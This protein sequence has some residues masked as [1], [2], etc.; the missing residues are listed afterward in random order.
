[1]SPSVRYIT[2]VPGY[3][4]SA[5]PRSARHLER[6]PVSFVVA[7]V[8]LLLLSLVAS[9]SGG[10][11][12]A[13]P[14]A[15]LVPASNPTAGSTSSGA[16]ESSSSVPGASAAPAAT[17]V[18]GTDGAS[19]AVRGLNWTEPGG[20]D[21][22]QYAV[23]ESTNGSLGPWTTVGVITTDTTVEDAVSS[24][25]PGATYW[26]EVVETYGLFGADTRTSNV[27]NATQPTL[28]YLT[29]PGL[30]STT[31]SFQW[32]NNASYGGL[33]SFAAYALYESVNGSAPGLAADLTDVGTV[34]Y[35]VTD[36]AAGTGYSFY[37]V[38]SDCYAECGMGTASLSSTQSNSLPLGTAFPLVATIS[39][40]RTVV[41]V[42]QPTSFTCTPSGG[43]KP[44]S[45]GWDF[46]NGTFVPGN[47]SVGALFTS[48]G[49]PVVECQV[50][51]GSSSESTAGTTILVNP[52]P[53]LQISVNRTTAD[54]DE[55][56]SFGCVSSNGTSPYS[57]AWTFGDDDSSTQLN[58]THFYAS[59]GMVVVTCSGTDEAGVHVA[60]SSSLTVS[61]PLLVQA[62][63]TAAAAAPGTSLTFSAVASNGSGTYPA[64]AWTFGD[65]TVASGD[66]TPHEYASA[67][68]FTA[69]VKVTD[70]NGLSATG[71]VAVTVASI[72]VSVLSA[73]TSSHSGAA[74]TFSASAT[75]GAGGPYTYTWN[76]GDGTTASGASVTHAYTSTGTFQ[77]TLVV[78]D[79]L[80]AQNET[81][82]ASVSVAPPPGLSAWLTPWVVL[83][84]ALLI[85]LLVAVVVYT[86][87]RSD[88]NL[89]SDRMSSYVPPTGPSRTMSGSKVCGFCDTPNLPIRK[90]CVACGKPLPRSVT[91]AQ[92]R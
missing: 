81:H 1:M 28:A 21:F 91:R 14:A 50:H 44:F 75:G 11:G 49:S 68:T 89:E 3:F 72:A 33:L 22:S 56:V 13:V 65:G 64:F 40:V 32:T 8:L 41:D 61:P 20:Y 85:G 5:M 18:L 90:T 76:F 84:I 39:T 83:L 12:R 34:N 19:P 79:R 2:T 31:A 57:L 53:S 88:E 45:I 63:V 55:P 86:R 23:D 16:I 60:A 26:W 92:N 37:L 59:P 77:P 6:I 4:L 82:L 54:V 15:P 24:L 46:G 51:D 27:I 7:I 78:T 80:G 62:A 73:P 67:G 74:A 9:V 17:F 71:S 66:S 42:G 47:T 29:S 25:S 87:R 70:S 38:T 30:T 43:V 48:P 52:S 35:T 10:A 36:L 58:V 69:R